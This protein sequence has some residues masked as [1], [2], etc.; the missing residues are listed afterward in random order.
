MA[1]AT[2]RKRKTVQQCPSR[3][4]KKP[5]FVF[6]I[7]DFIDHPD[8]GPM[9]I[10]DLRVNGY[11]R[12]RMF[13][14][15][16]SQREHTYYP[17]HRDNKW[18]LGT[19]HV[20]PKSIDEI[21]PWR[22]EL[23]QGD[24]VL[25][26]HEGK[27]YQS[28]ITNRE[29]MFVHIQPIGCAFDF[30]R[31]IHSISIM[32]RLGHSDF[33]PEANG[34]TSTLCGSKWTHKTSDR[35][36]QMIEH[37]TKRDI[38]LIEHET[39]G[40][41][42]LT[43]LEFLMNYTIEF[44]INRPQD[45]QIVIGE[46][47]LYAKDPFMCGF[48]LK[49]NDMDKMYSELTNVPSYLQDLLFSTS[50]SYMYPSFDISKLLQICNSMG[51]VK[52]KI[53]AINRQK[54]YICL[55]NDI[56]Y[57]I[58]EHEF[59]YT[60]R[61]FGHTV[62]GMKLTQSM[63]L[64]RN[65]SL[66]YLSA[67]G[68]NVKAQIIYHG[69]PPKA[70]TNNYKDKSNAYILNRLMI[71]F[72]GVV[73]QMEIVN[74]YQPMQ[75]SS[76]DYAMYSILMPYQT[77]AVDRMLDRELNHTQ[78]ISHAF[79]NDVNGMKY[80]LIKGCHPHTI[81][82]ATGGILQM[83]VGLGKTVCMIALYQRNPVKT[84]VVV[85]L[86]LIDQ[87]KIEIH[88]F[89]PSANVTEF[90]GKKKDS[91]GDI[92]LTTYGTVLSVYK[93]NASFHRIGRIIFDESHSIKS[94]TSMTCRACAEISAPY[95]WCLTATPIQ[96]VAINS[97]VP[98][99]CMLNCEPFTF[100]TSQKLT[101]FVCKQVE[102]YVFNRVTKGII[103]KYTRDGLEDHK[104]SYH[105]TCLVEKPIHLDIGANGEERLY[106]CLYEKCRQRLE[107]SSTK[108][109]ILLKSLID[110]LFL[111]GIDPTAVPIHFYSD[112]IH[113]DSITTNSMQQ[114]IDRIGSSA[115]DNSVKKTLED[116]DT[117]TCCICMDTIERPTITPCLHIYCHECISQQLNHQ[118][119]CPMCRKSITKESLV[120]I[121]EQNNDVTEDNGMVH[122]VDYIGRKCT[123][124]KDLYDMYH[125]MKPEETTK[126]KMVR[127]IVQDSGD[128][129]IIIFSQYKP[130]LNTLQKMF[131]DA[132]LITGSTSRIR[133]KKAVEKFQKKECKIFLLSVH[134]ASVGLTLTSGSQMIFMEPI[135]NESVKKQ[136]IG[137]I[138][139]TGQNK[140]IQIHTLINN[141]IDSF[142][143][144]AYKGLH[145]QVN[146]DKDTVKNRKLFFKTE[147]L[148]YL[149]P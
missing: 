126:H 23:K 135:I 2:S 94:V 65:I 89:I 7:G 47:E 15:P 31:H 69:V 57:D 145:R 85:P 58:N 24:I 82:D 67:E 26:S 42:W 101:S 19:L 99:L 16:H 3:K 110:K 36:V 96:N 117:T 22:K 127:K 106:Q 105:R 61:L 70:I 111:C 139:R 78:Y 75:T 14:Y 52:D 120:E 149:L 146:P 37:D 138:N 140:E 125:K 92:V 77:I 35:Q 137:R 104:M 46:V 45:P 84:L 8:V 76:S 102:D 87:W 43:T 63:N 59:L 91:S 17:T 148:N 98:Q 1:P 13:R 93:A 118:R 103:I 109:F 122:F 113:S 30:K 20:V 114:V 121:S 133:R 131:P 66:K 132:C 124:E 108:Q 5:D 123:M 56:P 33:V 144:K 54:I 116:L 55:Q 141:K 49:N 11:I 112:I 10:V 27:T 40:Y 115:F 95:R 60:G 38:V 29:D 6:K 128:D 107:K 88:K 100:T 50:C 34:C 97:I 134:C 142:M 136:A 119:K 130:V 129:S 79:E 18:Y 32:S 72:M 90:Y 39:Y 73:P 51:E 44:Q 143:V 81:A 86:T 64:H 21:Y 25:Y 28:I 147:A 71:E 68:K 62:R 48:H 83:D 12:C 53:I 4:K 41:Q 74:W 80:N 9:I